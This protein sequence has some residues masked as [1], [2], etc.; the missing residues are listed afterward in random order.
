MDPTWSE[1]KDCPALLPEGR[2]TLRGLWKCR[3]PSGV[4][5][6]SLGIG[7]SAPTRRRQ[8]PDIFR[9][10][11]FW[12]SVAMPNIVQAA[13]SIHPINLENHH[14]PHLR[15]AENDGLAEYPARLTANA[16]RDL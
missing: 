7:L 10:G 14:L 9:P 16:Q 12:P 11:I 6:R 4:Q 1:G 2:N 15:R 3:L 13:L 8:Y 5:G